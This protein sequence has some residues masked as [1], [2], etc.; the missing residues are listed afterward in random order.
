MKK[1]KTFGCATKKENLEEYEMIK[2]H[3]IETFKFRI[4]NTVTF[5][6]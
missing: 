5:N 6:F 4:C 3:Y 2:M 1:M